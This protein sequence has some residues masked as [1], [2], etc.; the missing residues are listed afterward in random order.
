LADYFKENAQEVIK[1]LTQE[2]SLKNAVKIAR[3]NGREIGK[4]EGI[5]KGIEKGQNDVL[6]LV[7]QGLSYEEIKKK[8]KKVS[9]KKRA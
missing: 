7:K 8:I 4:E 2:Y 9:K 1:M 3:E 6:E 5:E